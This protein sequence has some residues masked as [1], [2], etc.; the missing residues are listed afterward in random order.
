VVHG[1]DQ[2]LAEQDEA[3]RAAL[4]TR[5]TSDA[6]AEWLTGDTDYLHADAERRRKFGTTNPKRMPR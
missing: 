5:P 1:I 3:E 2:W 6:T 4:A